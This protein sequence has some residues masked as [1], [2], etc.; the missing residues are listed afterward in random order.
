MSDRSMG[1]IRVPDIGAIE[2][3]LAEFWREASSDE[4]AVLRATMLNL[5]VACEDSVSLADA[6]KTIAQLSAHLPGRALL[7]A[8]EPAANGGDA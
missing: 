1:Q 7:I 4:Q 6:S 8:T 3:E 5:V 2:K